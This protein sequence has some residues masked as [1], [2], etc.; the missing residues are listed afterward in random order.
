MVTESAQT[1]L[2]PSPPGAGSEPGSIVDQLRQSLGLLQVAFDAS[3]DALLIL[4][5]QCKVRWANQ[6]SAD[7]WASGLPILLPGKRFSDLISLYT[8]E[9]DRLVHS[10]PAHPI[11]RLRAGDGSGRFLIPTDSENPQ[12]SLAPHRISWRQVTEVPGGFVL[13][14]I[15]DL[16][17]VEQALLAE[18]MF[19]NQL[20]HELRTP[21]AI[22][23]GCLQRAGRQRSS[24]IKAIDEL[25]IA[26]QETRRINHLL[27]Q[28]S[29]L[30]QLEN[31]S[32]PWSLEQRSLRS[33]LEEWLERLSTHQKKR[34]SLRLDQ[35]S[36]DDQIELDQQAINRI[37]DQLLSNS[38]RFSNAGSPIAVMAEKQGHSY[39]VH[40]MDWGIGMPNDQREAVFERF[41]RLEARRNVDTCE[42]SGLG[43]TIVRALTAGMGGTAAVMPPGSSANNTEEPKTVIQLV[44][45][46]AADSPSGKSR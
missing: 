39:V 5:E 17:P 28:L 38:L 6:R 13:I 33:F 36:S 42:G 44:F 11:Q 41:H 25:H 27:E 30:S 37:L 4:D 35:L 40:F 15:R 29:L 45:P 3:P 7:H 14:S 2:T 32:Y 34:V 46:E 21:L 43:L 1:P 20:A 26:K 18:Q 12:A 31:G 22:I 19:M 8:D 9:G 16:E 10:H 24:K 23:T